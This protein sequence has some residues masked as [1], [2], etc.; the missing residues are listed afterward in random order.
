MCF[1]PFLSECVRWMNRW[2]NQSMDGS[3]NQSIF[4]LETQSVTHLNAWNKVQ[5]YSVNKIIGKRKLQLLGTAFFNKQLWIKWAL[6]YFCP[7]FKY[8][9]NTCCRSVQ[10]ASNFHSMS[11]GYHSLSKAIPTAEIITQPLVTWK[12]SRN[13]FALAK[14]SLPYMLTSQTRP[15]L[16]Q[17][18]TA[19]I[20]NPL[21]HFFW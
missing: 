1:F 4:R 10:K 2:I 6:F 8:A 21:P 13:Q 14:L 7:L 20:S 3:I 18:Y 11:H 15:T 19:L 5:C 9:I 16:W 17:E 12:P